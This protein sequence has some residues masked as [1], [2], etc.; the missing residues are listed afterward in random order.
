LCCPPLCRVYRP[1]PF[2]DPPPFAKRRP[3]GSDSLWFLAFTLELVAS[4]GIDDDRD[5]VGDQVRARVGHC[6]WRRSPGARAPADSEAVGLVDDGPVLDVGCATGR[7]LDTLRDRG[8][9][10]HGIDTCTEAVRLACAVGHSCETADVWDYRPAAPF[11]TV[12]ALGGNLGIA[13][14]LAMLGP[15]LRTLRSF[16]R[17]DGSLIVSSVDWRISADRH[18]SHIRRQ[19]DLGRYPGEVCL[20]LRF[21][22]IT[23]TWFPW[24]W[25]DPDTLAYAATQVGLTGGGD[26]MRRDATYAARLTVGQTP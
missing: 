5:E 9:R 19:Q 16:A 21:G 26:I 18:H 13:G 1:E 14:S 3:A 7:C 15:F 24:V 17:P 20:R 12:L 2:A 4:T 22:E 10:A 25:V 23:S 11:A 8:L 6:W